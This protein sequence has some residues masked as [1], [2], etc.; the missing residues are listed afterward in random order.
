LPRGKLDSQ[1]SLQLLASLSSRASFAMMGP[2]AACGV[3]PA[4]CAVIR[5][6]GPLRRAAPVFAVRSCLCGG[7]ALCSGAVTVTLGR[8]GVVCDAAVPPGPNNSEV[9]RIATA[10]GATRLDDIFTTRTPK[11]GNE[12]RPAADTVLRIQ[13]AF[14][15]T[16]DRRSSAVRYRA[17]IRGRYLYRLA[18][19][20]RNLPAIIKLVQYHQARCRSQPVNILVSVHCT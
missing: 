18:S 20:T 5:V 14:P 4:V 9:D 10:E 16:N 7:L 3:P 15:K 1:P 12:R 6:A 19:V 13:P 17:S 11:S 2:R 8:V